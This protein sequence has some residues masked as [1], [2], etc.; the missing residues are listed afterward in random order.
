M[1]SFNSS[2]KSGQKQIVKNVFNLTEILHFGSEQLLMNCSQLEP[3]I[4]KCRG[5]TL[6]EVA[7]TRARYK[8]AAASCHHTQRTPEQTR[9]RQREAASSCC[10]YRQQKQE[11]GRREKLP[12]V[13]TDSRHQHQV[14]GKATSCYYRQWIPGPVRKQ[15]LPCNCHYGQ[16][17]HEPSRREKLSAVITDSRHQRQLEGS[18]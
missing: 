16:Q 1:S 9:A 3:G 2:L 6:L 5:V 7:D 4:S 10:H 14:E 15:Q 13:I 8:E 17:T 18:S 12:A 11:P